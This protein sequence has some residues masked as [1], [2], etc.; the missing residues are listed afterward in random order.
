MP[1]GLRLRQRLGRWRTY[2]RYLRARYATLVRGKQRIPAFVHVPKTGGT[3]LARWHQDDPP[4]LWPIR[5]FAHAY[6]VGDDGALAPP[7]MDFQPAF[8]KSLVQPYFVFSSVRNPFDWLVS[9][10]GHAGGWTDRYRNPDHPDFEIANRPFPEF[11][12]ILADREERWPSRRLIHAQMWT[13]DGDFLPNWIHR[14]ESLDDDAEAMAQHLGCTFRR[15]QRARVG[16]RDRDY[17]TYYDD[18]TRELVERTW[19]RELR[20][21]GYDFDGPTGRPIAGP[22]SN[23]HRLLDD[24]FRDGLRYSW[25][26]DTLMLDGTVIE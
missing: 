21:F 3:H 7:G 22:E 11:I 5:Y 2:S 23:M 15:Q 20:L 17:R 6:V 9:Y 26:D 16:D 4:T 14:I 8:H 19:G 25:A 1:S 10:A 18:A 24:G 13:S 12:R